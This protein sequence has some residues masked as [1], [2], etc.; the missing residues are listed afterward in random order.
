[1]N[2]LYPLKFKPIYK[3]KI[4]GGDRL[5]KLLDKK[6]GKLS[7]CGESWEIS[8]VENEV[9]VVSN[10]FLKGNS[11][12]EL[13]E[14]YLSD[15]VGEKVYNR[16]G[17]EFPLLI[18]YIDAKDKLSIQVHP[19]DEL[20]KERHG[21]YGKTEMW[22]VIHAEEGAQLVTGFNRPLDRNEN[23]RYLENQELENIVNYENV[24]SGDVFFIPAGRVHS[25]G[26]GIV[27]AEIQ[28]TSDVTYRIYDFNRKDNFGN[29]R[30]LH[31]DLALDSID[32]KSEK[33][34]RTQY[35]PVDNVSTTLA[36]CQY[37]TT[38]VLPLTRLIERDFTEKDS[39]VIYM[40]IEGEY[41]LRWEEGRMGVKNGETVLVP[42]LINNFSLIPLSGN[43]TKLLEIY[44]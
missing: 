8:G 10:G 31:T 36:E 2:N 17:I 3:E 16:F 7:N 6:L 13:I 43:K 27:L 38:N 32:F 4:W 34:Y 30:E 29:L 24:K 40:C 23:S 35:E 19:N 20:A 44:I 25:I 9:S 18:K 11:L 26:K 1:M 33:N 37:F 21:A 28:E 39:F 12:E 41:T 5:K 14:I 42:A 22:Y 15:L